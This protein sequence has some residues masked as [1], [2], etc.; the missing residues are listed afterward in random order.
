VAGQ[1]RS[2]VDVVPRDEDEGPFVRPRVRQLQPVGRGPVRDHDVHVEGPG[3]PTDPPL[4][5][6]T[7]LRLLRSLPGRRGVHL[8][9][10]HR[11]E[12]VTLLDPADGAVS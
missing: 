5:R 1:H 6:R 11:V 12:E 7:V 2:G 4:A 9:E 10:Q 8:A 3:S